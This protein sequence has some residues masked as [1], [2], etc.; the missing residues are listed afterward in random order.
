VA[1]RYRS[2]SS[3]SVRTTGLDPYLLEA[4]ANGAATYVI[5]Y[6][7][8]H[9]EVRMFKLDRIRAVVLTDETFVAQGIDEIKRQLRDSWGVVMGDEQYDIVVDFTKD[10]APRVRETNWH[11]SQRLTKLEN[12]GV[13]LEL[14]LPSLLEFI[15]WVR[16][17]GAEAMVVGPQELRDEVSASLAAAAR[18]YG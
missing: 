2:Q 3:H 15:P 5:G 11:S 10:V 7:H 4:S 13:R 1:I 14:R 18:Q 8:E 17:W 16:G 12:G 9:R 6:S